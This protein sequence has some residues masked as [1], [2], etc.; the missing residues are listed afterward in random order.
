MSPHATAGR[1]AP[2]LLLATLCRVLPVSLLTLGVVLWASHHTVQGVLDRELNHRLQDKGAAAAIR[3]SDELLEIQSSIR[4]LAQN[5]LIIN[6]MVNPAQRQHA[7]ALL[8]RNL[9]LPSPSFQRVSLLDYRGRELNSS[10]PGATAPPSDLIRQVMGGEDYLAL[11]GTE[12]VA[13]SP[14]L[15]A[16][17]PEGIV[18]ASY[19]APEWLRQVVNFGPTVRV[20]IH[21][22]GRLA[23]QINE[24]PLSG[25][26][27]EPEWIASAYS[28]P[29]FQGLR[30]E[31]A[32][33][34][35]VNQAALH[36]LERMQALSIFGAIMAAFGSILLTAR[37]TTRPLQSMIAQLR[38]SQ[39]AGNK[40]A[41]IELSATAEFH[42]L[43]ETFHTLLADLENSTVSIEELKGKDAQLRRVNQDLMESNES[44]SQ[45]AFVASH[46]L[47]EPL[48][49]IRSFSQLLVSEFGDDLPGNSALYLRYIEEGTQRMTALIQD[50]L[51]YSRASAEIELV[52][53]DLNPCL[54]SVEE[55]LQALFE[56]RN[57]R[58]LRPDLPSV[59]GHAPHLS[60]LFQ[61]LIANGIKYNHSD[62]PTVTMAWE[63]S[64]DA[65]ILTITDNGIGI[66]PRYREQI[67]RLFRRLHGH[68]EYQGTGIGLALCRKI[69]TRMGGQISV[70]DHPGQGT[71][72]RLVLPNAERALAAET[73]PSQASAPPP[74]ARSA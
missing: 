14:V 9:R 15:Y 51:E 39:Q 7:V 23:L 46:D 2:T 64:E 66:E 60:V 3:V 61:N 20:R 34:S 19:D 62:E 47:Q 72:F 49:T 44:L 42:E 59:I 18:V 22:E 29:D 28:I 63:A 11:D 24:Q 30:M 71:R 13:A 48:R 74:I 70:V 21:R 68:D 73:P 55:D 54:Q 16:G 5:D 40:T 56:E 36:S 45:F 41:P 65:T 53:V 10:E 67:F 52:E 33:P 43:A 27:S 25:G 35:T 57:A 17:K 1:Q 31:V 6:S 58:F 8:F 26:P 4:L 38:A 12:L 50:V 32:E 69:V 37:L